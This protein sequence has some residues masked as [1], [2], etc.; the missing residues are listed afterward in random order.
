MGDRTFASGL[1]LWRWQ[2][3]VSVEKRTQKLWRLPRVSHYASIHVFILFMPHSK[4]DLRRLSQSM[5]GLTCGL[6]GG[7]GLTSGKPTTQ[8]ASPAQNTPFW[9]FVRNLPVGDW[10]GVAK[11]R[12]KFQWNNSIE[13][14][15]YPFLRNQSWAK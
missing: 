10:L 12:E 1:L 11:S 2:E 14:L 6:T 4:K 13:V 8:L 3:E 15:Q 9:P 5:R 7:L